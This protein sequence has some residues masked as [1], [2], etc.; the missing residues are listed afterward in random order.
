MGHRIELA[1]IEWAAA[2]LDGVRMACAVFD[3]AASRIYLY[4]VVDEGI[5]KQDI[6]DYCK[7]A[8]P[9]YMLPYAVILTERIPLTP[10]GKMDRMELLSRAISR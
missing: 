6:T 9:R 8:L 7:Q 5:T 10:N 2:R 3:G 1:E 4:C